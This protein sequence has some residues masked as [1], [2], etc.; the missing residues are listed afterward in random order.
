MNMPPEIDGCKLIDAE[1]DRH[2]GASSGLSA[3]ARGKGL[4]PELSRQARQHLEECERCRGL[5]EWISAEVTAAEAAPALYGKIRSALQSTLEPVSPLPSTRALA[6]Q[7]LVAFGLFVLPVSGILGFA[8]FHRMGLVQLIGVTVILAVGAATLSFSLA[9]QMTPGTLR[10]F[11][12]SV[13]VVVLAAGFLGCIG[14][15]FP[16][17]APKAFVAQ[18]WPCSVMGASI[19]VPAAALFW[20]LVRRGAPLSRETL[21]GALG[22][23]AGLLGVTVLQFSCSRQEAIHLLVWHG[24]VLVLTTLTGILVARAFKHFSVRSW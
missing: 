15:L 7:F 19:A 20:L 5:Y 16:W 8:G 24:G 12:T 18:G 23:I 11:S 14:I 6:T 13:A 4:R 9:W 2:F 22:A 3:E 1:L 10:R 17:R 21:G